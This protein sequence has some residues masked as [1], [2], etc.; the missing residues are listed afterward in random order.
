MYTKICNTQKEK[1]QMY[2]RL[3]KEIYGTL[4]AALLYYRKL[5]KELREYG[6]VIKPY[7][8]CVTN[9]WTDG[10]QLTMV[11]HVDDMKAPH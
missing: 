7:Y 2:V 8:P 3:S 4:K 10:G 5:S 9:K 6:F 11:W 1:K